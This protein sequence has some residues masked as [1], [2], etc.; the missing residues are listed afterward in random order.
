MD[1]DEKNLPK[2]ARERLRIERI[3]G[4]VETSAPVGFSLKVIGIFA[5]ETLIF[6]IS[7]AIVYAIGKSIVG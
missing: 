6:I 3:M 1:D 7:C 4:P 2:W 5:L